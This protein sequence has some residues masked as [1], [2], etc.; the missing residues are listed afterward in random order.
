MT[1]VGRPIPLKLKSVEEV[2]AITRIVIFLVWLGFR[3]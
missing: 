3:L 1:T 2:L